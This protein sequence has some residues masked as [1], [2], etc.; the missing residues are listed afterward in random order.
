M[1]IRNASYAQMLQ[2]TDNQSDLNLLTHT[3]PVNP[4]QQR[5]AIY[6]EP[7]SGATLVLPFGYSAP[8]W[9]QGLWVTHSTYGLVSFYY[10][11]NTISHKEDAQYKSSTFEQMTVAYDH[12]Q[13]WTMDAN[14]SYPVTVS[15][16]EGMSVRRLAYIKFM[17]S[18]FGPQQVKQMIITHSARGNVMLSAAAK[19]NNQRTLTYNPQYAAPIWLAGASS[20][21]LT[22]ISE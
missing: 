16:L 14:W 17:P 13:N 20:A 5:Y 19:L 7:D 10:Q 2:T 18:Q 21:F 1:F 6:R 22:T 9:K 3:F 4:K 11:I 8:E 12:P 15:T